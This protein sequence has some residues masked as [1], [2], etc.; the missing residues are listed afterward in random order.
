MKPVVIPFD[1]KARELI[2][3]IDYKDHP[4]GLSRKLQKYTVSIQ[5]RHWDRLLSIGSISVRAGL[6]PVLVDEGLYEK[7]TGLS[8]DDPADR[9]PETLYM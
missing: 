6:F 8:V 5:P 2:R 1:E 4:A 3:S 7:N 9:E